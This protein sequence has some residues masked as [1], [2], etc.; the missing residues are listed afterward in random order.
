MIPV[1]DKGEIFDLNEYFVG[2][3]D[4][5]SFNRFGIPAGST[6]FGPAISRNDT[7]LALSE[8]PSTLE[9]GDIVVINP[10]AAISPSILWRLRKI[11]S[12]HGDT[13][14]FEEDPSGEEHTIRPI[15]DICARVTHVVA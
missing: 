8:H 13:V 3:A 1:S 5:D 15:D 2:Q 10:V 7:G 4:G 14:R 12:I 11:R 6:F 9:P